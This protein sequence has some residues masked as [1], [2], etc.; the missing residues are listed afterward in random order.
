[1]EVSMDSKKWYMSKTIWAGVVAV[2]IAGYN[3]ASTQFGLPA[4]PEFVFG[5]LGIFGVYSRSTATTVIK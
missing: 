3:T 2:L 4:I 1:M 5:I